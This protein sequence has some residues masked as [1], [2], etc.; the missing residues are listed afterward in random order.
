MYEYML[1]RERERERKR[2]GE[3]VWSFSFRG[4]S[5]N[6]FTCTNA[7]GPKSDKHTSILM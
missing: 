6:I 2:E 3:R 7:A 1:E 4:C 5:M